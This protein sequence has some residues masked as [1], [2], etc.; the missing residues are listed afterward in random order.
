M[1]WHSICMAY[2]QAEKYH[3]KHF[4]FLGTFEIFVYLRS[5]NYLFW[6]KYSAKLL[7]N[8]HEKVLLYRHLRFFCIYPMMSYLQVNSLESAKYIVQ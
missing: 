7:A 5:E 4:V 2:N 8:A 1:C 3:I 6:S